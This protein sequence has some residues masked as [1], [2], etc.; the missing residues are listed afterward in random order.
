MKK[1]IIIIGIIVLFISTGLSGCEFLDDSGVQSCDKTEVNPRIFYVKPDIFYNNLELANRVET[2]NRSYSITC[3]VYLVPCG[4]T[5]SG[6]NVFHFTATNET[7]EWIPSEKGLTYAIGNSQDYIIIQ[8]DFE[9]IN[10]DSPERG[11]Y[12]ECRD[13]QKLTYDTSF[14]DTDGLITRVIVLTFST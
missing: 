10:L 6:S 9:Y 12:Y 1:Q 2:M 4:R 13:T 3:T 11:T 7:N 5:A 14:S 8:T